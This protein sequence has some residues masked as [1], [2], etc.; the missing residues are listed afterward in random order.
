[1]RGDKKDPL[2]KMMVDQG[3]PVEDDVMNPSHTS[4][5][6]FPHKVD[7]GAVFRTDMTA[8][9]QLE[10]WKTYQEYW[11]EHKPSVTISVK[12]HEWLEVG[13]WTYENFNYMSGVSFLPFS[14]H[15]YK[16]AP[17]Q[18]CTKE[19][20]EVLLTKMPKNVEWNKLSEYEQT[21]MTIG[22]Q[23]LA[24]AAGFCEIQ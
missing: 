23:E 14:E 13:A 7:N 24:C 21:D 3:F 17:Y 5:F 22:A 16:Q 10:L 18:D 9:D 11:C 12:E 15:T 4:V 1:M 2:T 19:E 8:I 6:S 20:Y